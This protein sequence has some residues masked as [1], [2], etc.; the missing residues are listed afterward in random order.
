MEMCTVNI[1]LDQGQNLVDHHVKFWTS[2]LDP[3]IFTNCK[4]LVKYDLNQSKAFPLI[5][6]L[7][8]IR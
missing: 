8:D 4:H 7:L 6:N 3:L 2:D 1:E 5:P